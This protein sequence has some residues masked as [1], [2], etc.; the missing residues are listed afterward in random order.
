MQ[1]YQLFLT[2]VLLTPKSELDTCLRSTKISTFSWHIFVITCFM[3]K[4]WTRLIDAG[5]IKV[6]GLKLLPINIKFMSGLDLNLDETMHSLWIWMIRWFSQ[7]HETSNP[8]IKKGTLP[9]YLQELPSMK[10]LGFSSMPA[11]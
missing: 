2:S 7:R 4:T 5:E 8:G 3:T 6:H 1:L 11:H 10:N 9:F